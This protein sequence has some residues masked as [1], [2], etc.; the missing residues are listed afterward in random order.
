M[1]QHRRDPT[2]K[3]A[4]VYARDTRM[5]F[6]ENNKSSRKAVRF[7]KAN[8]HRSYRKSVNQILAATELDDIEDQAL[9]VER[10]RWRKLPDATLLRHLDN[11][12]SGSSRTQNHAE[13]GHSRARKL[14]LLELRRKRGRFA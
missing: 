4:L 8:N 2:A 3:K 14:A 11:K 1:K 7:R 13:Y 12:W 9:D 6:G 10:K 5:H